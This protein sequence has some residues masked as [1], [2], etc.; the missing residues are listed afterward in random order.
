[1]KARTGRVFIL[2]NEVNTEP[3]GK[4]DMPKTP[5]SKPTIGA[6]GK[7]GSWRTFDPIVNRDE[8][9]KCR[10]CWLYCPEAV[11]NI[12]EEGYPVVDFDYCKGCGICAEVCPKKCIEMVR[13]S[14]SI[15]ASHPVG[16]A[17]G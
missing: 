2:V 14:D 12:D 4:K 6:T 1:V 13:T 17:E 5:Y 15:A 7:T 11:I 16:A 8:C 10:I 9:N 3:T